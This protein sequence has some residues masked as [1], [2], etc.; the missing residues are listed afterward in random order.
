MIHDSVGPVAM[1]GMRSRG[2]S[3]ECQANLQRLTLALLL[4]EKEH[5]QLPDGDWREAVQMAAECRCPSHPGLAE[6]ETTYAMVSGVPNA[7]PTIGP[8][9]SQILL[10]ETREPQRDGRIPFEQATFDNG[11]GSNHFR[12]E[13][14]VALRSGAVRSLPADINPVELRKHLDGTGDAP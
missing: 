1:K 11:L 10:V 4:Y 14:N 2:R 9:P 3:L 7:M 5:G 12:N 6:G 13:I 8:S